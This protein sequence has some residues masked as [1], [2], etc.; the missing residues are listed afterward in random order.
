MTAG[1]YDGET[2][3]G[4]ARRC[5]VPRVV[6]LEAVPSTMDIAHAE[7]EAG[8]PPGTLVLTDR[9]TEGRGRGGKSWQ[10]A[11]GGSLTMTLIERPID[12]AAIAVLSLRL[13]LAV[14]P[15]LEQWTDGPV[16][17]KWP[18]DVFVGDGKLGGILVEARWRNQRPEWVAIG[19]GINVVRP[20]LAGSAGLAP[21]V[22][23]LE[24]LPALVTAVRE[25]VARTGGLA[26]DEVAAFARRDRARGRRIV[27][28]A[29]GIAHGVSAGGALLVET[30]DGLVS[31]ATGSLVF[32]EE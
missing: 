11:A 24:I 16:R 12:D 1:R 23:R 8:A 20:T 5:G 3:D 4:L 28:P 25:A 21:G 29:R 19:L 31:C 26:P 32:M 17:L 22:S 14:A 15:A 7:G 9:Q 18:N 13:G 6:L 27:E 10:S 2:A 30:V